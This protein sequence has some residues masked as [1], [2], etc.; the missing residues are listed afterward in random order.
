ML[1]TTQRRE[2]GKT[3]VALSSVGKA[4]KACLA[5]GNVHRCELTKGLGG[6]GY[7]LDSGIWLILLSQS[8]MTI[9]QRRRVLVKEGVQGKGFHKGLLH[10]SC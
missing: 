3:E 9:T 6:T 7:S 1:D 4:Y 10:V 5:P 8:L 2:T